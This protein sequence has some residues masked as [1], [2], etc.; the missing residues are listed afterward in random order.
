MQVARIQ[1][2]LMKKTVAQV[3]MFLFLNF[4]YSFFV[5]LNVFYK[6]KG[7]ILPVFGTVFLFGDGQDF[8][9]NMFPACSAELLYQ[10]I[11]TMLSLLLP[12]RFCCFHK[13]PHWKKY[14]T[15]LHLPSCSYI[16][17]PY[18]AVFKKV[19]CCFWY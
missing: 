10:T 18:L 14:T 5:L 11:L 2:I 17:L 3:W 6:V 19:Y 8:L 16:P 15:N 7:V 9:P 4:P 13:T 1:S 12:C